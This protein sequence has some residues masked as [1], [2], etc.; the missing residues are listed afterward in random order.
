M[1]PRGRPASGIVLEPCETISQQPVDENRLASR[2]L[3]SRKDQHPVFV[4]RTVL[5][6]IDLPKAKQDAEAWLA[7]VLFHDFM[8]RE[9]LR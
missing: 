5:R 4:E 6:Q 3:R 8:E 1:K 2:K 9:G 7:D